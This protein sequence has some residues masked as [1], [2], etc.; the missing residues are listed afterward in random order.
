MVTLP[1]NVQINAVGKTT[2]ELQTEIRNRYVPDYYV[3]LTVNVKAEERFY[4]V[5]GEV[6]IPSRQP[7]LGE[8]TVMRA[9]ASAGGFTEFANKSKIELRR[10][11]GETL[12]IN[13]SKVRSNPKLDPQVFPNDQIVVPKK[14]L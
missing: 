12:R 4:Y 13:S 3:N 2:G 7:Y 6:K 11:N 10:A 14:I 5:D 8:M 9:I 1:Y